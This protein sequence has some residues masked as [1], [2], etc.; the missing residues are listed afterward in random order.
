VR[1]RPRELIETNASGAEPLPA[2]PKRAKLELDSADPAE[3]SNAM[4]IARSA[5]PA[6]GDQNESYAQIGEQVASVLAAAQQAA[7]EIRTKALEEAEAIR[8]EA[9]REAQQVRR[10]SEALGAE[11]DEYSRQTREAADGYVATTRQSVEEEAAQRRAE[12]DQ[13][14]RE[15][16]RAA[17]QQAREIETEALK[18]RTA[19]IEEAKRSEA[20][21]EQLLG[22]YRGMT[23]QLEDVLRA[24]RAEDDAVEVKDEQPSDELADDLRPKRSRPEA[25]SERGAPT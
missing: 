25:A 16:H 17:E 11:A 13:E 8:A 2:E 12:L 9:G 3:R 24:A 14:V 1:N 19:I 21:L 6:E 4:K 20:R 7:E 22:V 15:T 5:T 23:S 18:R 10:E